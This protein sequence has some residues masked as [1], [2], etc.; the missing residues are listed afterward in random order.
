MFF[1][2]RGQCLTD[3]LA[4]AKTRIYIG[5]SSTRSCRLSSGTFDKEGKIK[6]YVPI[7]EIRNLKSTI[8]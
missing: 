4:T 5:K 7:S 3:Q 8:V 6:D 1:S 2:I